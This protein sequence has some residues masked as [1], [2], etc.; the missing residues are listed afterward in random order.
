MESNGTI[1]V[2]TKKEVALY[3]KEAARLENFLGGIKEMKKLPDALIV[4]DPIED[5][6]AV[7]EARK[8]HIPVFGLCD[9]N[10]WSWNYF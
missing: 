10:C 3:R 4:V 5:K 8:L 6:T 1:N 7:L 9:T 2:Y